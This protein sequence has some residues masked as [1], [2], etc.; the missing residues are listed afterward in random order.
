MGVFY[1]VKEWGVGKAV[2]YLDGSVTLEFFVSPATLDRPQKSFSLNEAKPIL[3]LEPQTRVFFIDKSSGV[4]RFGRLNWQADDDC[5]ISLPNGQTAEV[6]AADLFVRCSNR[7]P[8]PCDYLESRLTETPFF[9]T[10][11]SLLVGHLLSQRAV[12]VGMTGLLSAPIE[13]ERHQV[14][15]VRRV[16]A[17]P[18]QRYLLADEVG[19]GKTIEAGVILR[20]YVLDSP[21]EHC[22]LIVAPPG[23]V[24][25]WQD[26]LESRLQIGEKFGHRIAVISWENIR[27]LPDD[28]ECPNFVVID[29][30][31]QI[32]SGW[33]LSKGDPRR[34][35]FEALCTLTSPEQCPRLLLLSATPV[36]RNEDSFLALLHLLDPLVYRLEDRESF[37]A[38]V[39]ARQ[40]LADIF[41]TFTDDQQNLFLEEMAD[42]LMVLFPNDKRLIALIGQ[43][44][45]HL[46]LTTPMEGAERASAIRTVR[47]HLHETYRLHRR[48]LRN[49][50]SEELSGILPGRAGLICFSTPHDIASVQIAEALENWRSAAASS[51]WGAEGTPAASALRQIYALLLEASFCDP[52]ALQ[53]YI[54]LRLDSA[55]WEYQDFGP[56]HCADS[57]ARLQDCPLFESEQKLLRDI[58]AQMSGVPSSEESQFEAI[59]QEVLKRSNQAAR[60]TVFASSPDRANRAFRYLSNALRGRVFRHSMESEEWRGFLDSS[61]GVLV[62]DYR[63]EE[64]LNLHGGRTFMLHLDWPLSPNRIE[65]RIGRLDRFGVGYSVES[66]GYV[67]TG[68]PQMVAWVHC[69]ES[70]WQVFNQ[71]IAAL[72]FV[73]DDASKALR[74]RLLI[75]GEQAIRD[76]I[77]R[78]VGSDGLVK[79]ELN[80]LRAQDEL[81]AVDIIRS[82]EEDIATNILE[83]E[84]QS[85][86]FQR[87]VESWLVDRLQFFRVGLTG[88]NDNV[89]RYHLRSANSGRQT[90]VP[91]QDFAKWFIPSVDF[92]GRHEIF[93]SPLTW[94]VAYQR[95]TSRHRKV[96][97]ARLGNPL[98]DCLQNYLHW[99]DRGISFAFWRQV[100]F[101]EVGK[102]EL[103]FRYDFCVEVNLAS[104]HGI[105]LSRS[106]LA[107]SALRRMADGAFPPIVLTLW[108]DENLSV[109][110]D[111]LRNSAIEKP[112]QKPP[113]INLNQKR[114]PMVAKHYP[115]EN[116]TDLCRSAKSLAENILLEKTELRRLSEERASILESKFSAIREQM[117]SRIE[118]LRAYDAEKLQGIEELQLHESIHKSLIRAIRNPAVQVNSAGVVFLA[119]MPLET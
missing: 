2:D 12:A 86:A 57:I 7:S 60:V 79:K 56:L 36:R 69:L 18:V 25:Q 87:S 108:L 61:N 32:A 29:E 38:K 55:N 3:R 100:P 97:L 10:A 113:D 6:N 37:R 105:L 117:L 68:C 51:I 44:K 67:P 1:K 94:P 50:R 13:I 111:P 62:C 103:F 17:D 80:S 114:W 92:E 104:L 19:L 90:L 54:Q 77:P 75:D 8:D 112:Y 110:K 26:E 76:E 59:K 73:V 71:S 27:S 84:T 98:V 14:E 35:R 28:F 20:Q 48:V 83:W 39:T 49:R 64:G 33:N 109:P 88:I 21:E 93:S 78:L 66:V 95:Q 81:D 31:H 101:L 52:Y 70:A 40:E 43:L 42:Q 23:L 4:W 34:E 11:R 58:L 74:D 82:G 99:D 30:A 15:V 96:G 41:Y 107:E 47:S 63:A 115:L 85:V 118:A 46:K 22:A 16:L 91:K 102:V 9:H 45:P 24:R 72:Q 106:G 53:N 65:Q 116:W 5:Y 119:G 89:A